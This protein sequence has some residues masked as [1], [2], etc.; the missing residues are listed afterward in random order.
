MLVRAIALRNKL[1]L[2]STTQEILVHFWF[3][4]VRKI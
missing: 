2:P 3:W 4:S 1:Y